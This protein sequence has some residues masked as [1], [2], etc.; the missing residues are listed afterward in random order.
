[1]A[2]DEHSTSPRQVLAEASANVT[3]QEGLDICTMAYQFFD[4]LPSQ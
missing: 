4:A 3:T 2:L 1:V